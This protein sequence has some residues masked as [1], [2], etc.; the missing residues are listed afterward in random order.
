MKS[1]V[2]L[3]AA[4]SADAFLG[5]LITFTTTL[6]ALLSSVF[7]SSV[8]SSSILAFSLTSIRQSTATLGTVL[9]R[10]NPRQHG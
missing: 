3:F 1:L 6:N 9:M 10:P 8:F 7:S 2:K 5:Y 4:T